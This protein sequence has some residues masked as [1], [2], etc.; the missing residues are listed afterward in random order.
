MRTLIPRAL[1]CAALLGLAL[2]VAV[3]KRAPTLP[4]APAAYRCE[5]SVDRTE[6]EVG[7]AI[8][9]RAVVHNMARGPLALAEPFASLRA[10][11]ER[12]DDGRRW[13]FGRRLACKAPAPRALVIDEGES[14]LQLDVLFDPGVDGPGTCL[15][16]PGRYRLFAEYTNLKA[17]L[18]QAS[19]EG[20]GRLFATVQA[21]AV[22]FVVRAPSES[23]RKALDTFVRS[24]RP[25]QPVGRR[26]LFFSRGLAH[27]G[28]PADLKAR[29]LWELAWETY[30]AGRVEESIALLTDGLPRAGSSA[31]LY[32]QRIGMLLDAANRPEEAA[33]YLAACESTWHRRQASA[34]GAAS[35]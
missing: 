8:L 31:E 6:Y 16:E 2:G 10:V 12:L 1:G 11:L 20:E 9:V 33:G 4:D 29:L 22:E 13:E 3:T 19:L 18:G 28:M 24:F 14:W 35:P 5:V 32:R 26:A 30:D 25:E 21:E 7:E 27:P 17:G 15:L 23:R 34:H